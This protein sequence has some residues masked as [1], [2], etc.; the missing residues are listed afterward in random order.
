MRVVMPS[1]EEAQSHLGI[2]AANFHEAM[3]RGGLGG[4]H[5]KRQAVHQ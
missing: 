4:E 3:D 5:T 1:L 2:T